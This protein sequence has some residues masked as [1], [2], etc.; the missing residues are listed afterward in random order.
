MPEA[1]GTNKLPN[2][3][4]NVSSYKPTAN[5]PLI[6]VAH[7]GLEP[8]ISALRGQRVNQLH[9]CAASDFGIIDVDDVPRKLGFSL[10]SE[11]QLEHHF[12]L[13]LKVESLNQRALAVTFCSRWGVVYSRLR[14]SALHH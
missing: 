6:L 4:F 12:K 5:C 9:Q 2:R 3:Q 7:T 11:L 10:A 13:N 14:N 8:V 1:I